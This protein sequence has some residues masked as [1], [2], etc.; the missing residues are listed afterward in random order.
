MIFKKSQTS[1][2][3][4]TDVS[5]YIADSFK[6][7]DNPMSAQEH[8]RDNSEQEVSRQT[9]YVFSSDD[10]DRFE[11]MVDLFRSGF[12][13]FLASRKVEFPNSHWGSKNSRPDPQQDFEF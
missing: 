10:I 13:E 12:W 11:E 9:V 1:C 8:A 2:G 4:K 7:E 3:V 6:N 5:A